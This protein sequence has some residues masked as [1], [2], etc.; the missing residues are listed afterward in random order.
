MLEGLREADRSSVGGIEGSGHEQCG[1][2]CGK[3]TGAMWEGL[4]EADR[5]RV[6]RI[7]GS[8]QEQCKWD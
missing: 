4:R 8:G 2:D 7:K 3:R 6:E 1:R 5:N